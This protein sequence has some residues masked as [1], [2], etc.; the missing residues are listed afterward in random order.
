MSRY[1]FVVGGCLG[2]CLACG[3]DITTPCPKPWSP[4]EPAV[5][6]T[7]S[8]GTM[9]AFWIPV[10]VSLDGRRFEWSSMRNGV[11]TVPAAA[12]PRLA[13]ISA[14][15]PGETTILAVDLNSPDNCPDIWAGTVVVR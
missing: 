7:L 2:L 8:V 15:G 14:V 4:L 10:A 11:A 9:G 5:A 1:R 12:N 6:E 13:P 3:R